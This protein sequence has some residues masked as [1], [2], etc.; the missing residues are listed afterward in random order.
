MLVSNHSSLLPPEVVSEVAFEVALEVVP[1]VAADDVPLV[2]APLDVLLDVELVSE[3]HPARVKALDAARTPAKTFLSF[4]DI[5]P[6]INSVNSVT[7]KANMIYTFSLNYSLI[8]LYF[9]QFVKY[10]VYFR[11]I[12][13]LSALILC[14]LYK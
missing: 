5:P 11:E 8:I 4:I 3:P 6:L 7:G 1:E 2:A 10:L 12:N 14:S 13:Q 9:H